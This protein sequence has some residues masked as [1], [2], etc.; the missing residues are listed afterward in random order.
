MVLGEVQRIEVVALGLDQRPHRAGEAELV[1]D[2]ADLIH[3][4][5][6][7]VQ[8]AG[9]AGTAWHGEIDARRGSGGAFE[10]ALA[11]RERPL[12]V[13]LQGV[14]GGADPLPGGRL[15]PR[16][17]GE[18]F[19]ERTGLTAEDLGLELREPAL[20]RLRDLR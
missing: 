5:R 9:P 11:G 1:E 7:E 8:P 10:L 12:E 2:L 3:D 18:D 17:R 15:E 16:Q 13:V 20:V 6:D 4:L 19:G 14:G